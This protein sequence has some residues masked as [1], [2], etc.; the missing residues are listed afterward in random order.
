[1]VRLAP[2]PLPLRP[3]HLGAETHLDRRTLLPPLLDPRILPP[4]PGE[5]PKAGA[6]F[7]EVILT[8]GQVPLGKI[9]AENNIPPRRFFARWDLLL[10]NK[11]VA[12]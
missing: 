9:L 10:T 5:E 6:G 7:E 2:V 12:N 3:A 11:Q 4:E 1:M 8:W